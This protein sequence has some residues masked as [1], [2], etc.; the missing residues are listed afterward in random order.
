[1]TDQ[2]RAWI[3]TT[4]FMA[5]ISG[6][7]TKDEDYQ[8][9]SR[10]PRWNPWQD[11]KQTPSRSHSSTNASKAKPVQSFSVLG[12]HHGSPLH[13]CSQQV[14]LTSVE[15]CLDEK[16]Q[17]QHHPPRPRQPTVSDIN[18]VVI[19][20]WQRHYFDHSPILSSIFTFTSLHDGG[21]QKA[22]DEVGD[23]EKDI[24]RVERKS[25]ILA[26]LGANTE[27]YVR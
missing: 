14:P 19:P 9:K 26:K 3:G 7:R 23:G 15:E 8:R 11:G 6:C 1:M 21:T 24:D 20:I 18:M 16:Y 5:S 27:W 25:R 13:W 10:G 17:R 12:W 2:E 22:G 4:R